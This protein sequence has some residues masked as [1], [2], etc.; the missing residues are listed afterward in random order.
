[1]LN[2]EDGGGLVLGG[3][4][5]YVQILSRRTNAPFVKIVTKDGREQVMKPQ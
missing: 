5:G 1:M 3:N 2:N 4:G